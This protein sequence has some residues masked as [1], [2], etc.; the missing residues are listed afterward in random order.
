ML[1]L[2]LLPS[3]SLQG[4]RLAKSPCKYETK[5]R[6]RHANVQQAHS[7]TNYRK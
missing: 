6:R 4:E 1:D 2:Q 3:D 7:N 5:E